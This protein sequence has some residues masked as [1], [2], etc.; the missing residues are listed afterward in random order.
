MSV[1][2][3][4]LQDLEKRESAGQQ[5]DMSRDMPMTNTVKKR[6]WLRLITLVTA[7]CLI[8]VGG[9]YFW[10]MQQQVKQYDSLLKEGISAETVHEIKATEKP[11]ISNISQLKEAIAEVSKEIT[12]AGNGTTASQTAQSPLNTANVDK[13][14]ELITSTI[15]ASDQDIIEQNAKLTELVETSSTSTPGNTQ[16]T[17]SKI[18]LFK[19]DETQKAQD[20]VLSASS[21]A[22]SAKTIVVPTKNDGE[23]QESAEMHIGDKSSPAL[24]SVK[25]VS[26]TAEQLANKAFLVGEGYKNRGLLA[27]AISQYQLALQ[28]WP[29]H[30]AS[31]KQIA[32]LLFAR[33]EASSALEVLE[34]GLALDTKNTELAVV[35]AK[36][37]MKQEL[38]QRGLSFLAAIEP[39]D[40]TQIPAIALRAS[41]A[42]KAKRYDLALSDY[43]QLL[44]LNASNS[45]W[46]LGKAIALDMLG[47]FAEAVLVYQQV[48]NSGGIS[49]ASK[50]Y[51]IKRLQAL[52]DKSNG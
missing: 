21:I 1:I 45:R 15:A 11:S 8:V 36:I 22:E 19:K 27:E 13:V 51:A 26:V 37:C 25:T 29:T 39:T 4:M 7:P 32:A 41:L 10:I 50:Q 24:F 14:A 28:R 12:P 9:Y 35:A 48:L 18:N 2:N 16:S 31:R 23:K 5:A 46:L 40:K 33:N 3:K 20:S 38:Y 47:R 34:Q 43:E 6:N 30:S 52:R 44:S 17:V 49:L 42:Q